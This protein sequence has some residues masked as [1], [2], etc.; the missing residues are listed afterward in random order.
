MTSFSHAT[1]TLT[2]LIPP[3]RQGKTTEEYFSRT[4]FRVIYRIQSPT[5]VDYLHPRIGSI[6]LNSRWIRWK[7]RFGRTIAKKKKVDKR[8]FT[9]TLDVVIIWNK[10]K[11]L[12]GNDFF[13]TP[14]SVNTLYYEGK[15][16]ARRE[17]VQGLRVINRPPL[18]G[19]HYFRTLFASLTQRR[20]IDASAKIHCHARINTPNC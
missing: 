13:V 3:E 8:S 1:D 17:R 2:F 16:S 18:E 12:K 9:V 10:N 14:L 5:T 20:F 15:K 6:Q 11:N 19:G 7:V 4:H